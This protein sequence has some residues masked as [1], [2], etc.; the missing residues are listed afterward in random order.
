VLFC[1]YFYS[2]SAHPPL[3]YFTFIHNKFFLRTTVV[4]Q[5]IVEDDSF[6]F[7]DE[8][9]SKF[10][11]IKVPLISAREILSEDGGAGPSAS[12]SSAAGGG[13]GAAAKA[14]ASASAGGEDDL[15]AGGCGGDSSSGGLPPTVEED[16]RHLVEAA[17]VRV[18]KARKRL[19]HNDL[20]AEITRQLSHRFVPAP[21]VGTL[22][23]SI[24]FLSVTIMLLYTTN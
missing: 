8:F 3:I 20:V 11:R 7:N 15:I 5:G 17:I 4:S 14:Y 18:M 6:T 2:P 1:R 9:T 22:S 19:S 16:R 13:S 10:K 24:S 12:A 21:Q 23:I